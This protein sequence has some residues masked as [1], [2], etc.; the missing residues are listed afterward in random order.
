MS[1]IYFECVDYLPLTKKKR[2]TDPSKEYIDFICNIYDDYYDDRKEDSSL[3]GENWAPGE[4]AMHTSIEAFRRKLSEIYGIEISTAKIR[5]ILITGGRYTTERS[6]E[7]VDC[8]NKF[9]NI[10]KV[11]TEL[12]LTTSL[13]SIYLPYGRTVYDL[14]KKSGNAKRIERLRKEKK[15]DWFGKKEKNSH[16]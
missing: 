15:Q 1:T 16:Q 8:F 10:Q 5:K 14:K 9:H 7:V 4:K 13:V 11:A 12:G 2:K 6:R 3:G